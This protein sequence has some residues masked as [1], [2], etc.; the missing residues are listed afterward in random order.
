MKYLLLFLLLVNCS[1]DPMSFDPRITIGKE[2]IKFF[3][4]ETKEKPT[5]E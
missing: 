1:K 4:E 5:I 3:Y 2:I